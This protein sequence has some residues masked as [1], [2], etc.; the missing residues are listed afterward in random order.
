V[1]TTRNHYA[2]KLTEVRALKKSMREL[3]DCYWGAGDGDEPPAFIKRAIRLS[4]YRP[5]VGVFRKAP[6]K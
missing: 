4:G 3:L 2:R 6:G 1:T 5:P